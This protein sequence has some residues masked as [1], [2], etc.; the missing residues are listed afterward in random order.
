MRPK[1]SKILSSLKFNKALELLATGPGAISEFLFNVENKAYKSSSRLKGIKSDLV[2]SLKMI[3]SSVKGEYKGLSRD[4]LV[5]FI[6]AFLYFLNPL[7]LIPDFLTPI[8]LTD[9][10]SLLIWVF[11]K[12]KGELDDYKAWLGES[13][14][15]SV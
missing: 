15:E 13:D 10:L 12:F 9:D 4:S 6:A 8:G 1:L 7:D 14:G 11:A 5:I 3:K 2:L